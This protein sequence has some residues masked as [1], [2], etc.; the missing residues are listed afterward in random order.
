[1]RVEIRDLQSEPVDH[2]LLGRVASSVGEAEQLNLDL[3]SL[4]LVDDA[5]METLNCTLRNTVGTTDVIAF[6]AEVG[7][8]GQAEAEAYISVPQAAAQAAEHGHSV[9]WELA[10]LVA[11]AVL[12]AAGYTDADPEDRAAM[13]DRQRTILQEHKGL[14]GFA[15]N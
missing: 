5:T 13:L 10:F 14:S 11:H 1:M 8:D 15:Q 4:V 2:D 7:P 3:L 9:A 6:E 12:H